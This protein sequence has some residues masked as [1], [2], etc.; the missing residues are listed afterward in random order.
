[1]EV[2]EQ[3]Q[4]SIVEKIKTH[5]GG[6]LKGR[7]FGI[8]KLSF[9]PETDDIREARSLYISDALAKEGVTM[10][11]YDPEAIGTFKPAASPDALAKMEFIHE[12]DSILNALDALIICAEWN[13]IR[14]TDFSRCESSMR[15]PVI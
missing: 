5:Y 7:T 8:W 9:K 4:V 10:K 2:N 11:A 13:E 14:R 15:A 3:Q 12:R 6:D 1:M